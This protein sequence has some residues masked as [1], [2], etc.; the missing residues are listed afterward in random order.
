M[1]HWVMNFQCSV[2]VHIYCRIDN[3]T[4]LYNWMGHIQL[5]SKK[6]NSSTDREMTQNI[7]GW[8]KALSKRRFLQDRHVPATSDFISPT[9][10]NLAAQLFFF[11]PPLTP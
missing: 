4:N 1:A 10:H 2:Y 11:S 5:F 7:C 8:I 6:E 3:K 9:L